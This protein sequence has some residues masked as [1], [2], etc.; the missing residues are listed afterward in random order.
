MIKKYAKLTGFLSNFEEKN[1]WCGWSVE[2]I[3]HPN[4]ELYIYL[5]YQR[6]ALMYHDM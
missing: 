5:S 1:Y 4:R 6:N 3:Q 2:P